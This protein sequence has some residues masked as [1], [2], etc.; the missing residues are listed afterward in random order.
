[1]TINGSIEQRPQ[2]GKDLSR[3]GVDVIDPALTPEQ[4]LTADELDVLSKFVRPHFMENLLSLLECNAEYR[5]LLK[6]WQSLNEMYLDRVFDGVRFC[7]SARSA[8]DED[9]GT[10]T[11]EVP[12]ATFYQ[13]H[14]CNIFWDNNM[15]HPYED[16]C[17]DPEPPLADVSKLR[18]SV[19]TL[20]AYFPH[21][22]RGNYLPEV[23]LYMDA[24]TR[25]SQ[26]LGCPRISI[27]LPVFLHEMAHAWFDR[28]PLVQPKPY[29]PYVE[30]PIA[31]SLS[32]CV[33]HAFTEASRYFGASTYWQQL[34][35]VAYAMVYRK[36][37]VPAIAHYSLGVELFH[38]SACLPQRYYL[39]SY[40]LCESS[41][42]VND[43]VQLFDGGFPAR[44]YD[45][46]RT[47]EL[48]V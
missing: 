45:A 7:L 42:D 44:P 13:G 20:G 2:C 12:T 30:E 27:V 38:A 33:L 28:F 43:Y 24:I 19:D 3:C 29:I 23:H 15:R 25:E 35:D 47:L 9:E 37:A 32:L 36:R 6:V 39:R 14:L 8:D 46:G 41:P 48:L 26:R 17:D 18:P 5:P 10:A 31:E 4:R 21:A 11:G 40:Y 16:G 1:M 22:T 34:F